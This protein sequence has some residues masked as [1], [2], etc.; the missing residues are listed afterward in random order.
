MAKA[1]TFKE[2]Q[3]EI[4]KKENSLYC[5]HNLSNVDSKKRLTLRGIFLL[6]L[7]KI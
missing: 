4:Q 6:L 5:I 3:A 7:V 1:Y 2:I